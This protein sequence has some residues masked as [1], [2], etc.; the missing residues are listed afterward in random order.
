MVTVLQEDVLER[1]MSRLPTTD[2]RLI[3][4]LAAA[5]RRKLAASASRIEVYPGDELM[6]SGAEIDRLIFPENAPIMLS[7][8]TGGIA[9]D[10]GLI[11]HDGV[12]GWSRLLGDSPAPFSATVCV[13]SG[14]AITIP[15]AAMLDVA[16][17]DPAVIIAI[18]GFA[19]RFTM[20]IARTLGAALRDA[21]DRRIARLLL[22]IDDRTSGDTMAITHAAIARM[23][24]LRRA[25]VTDCLHVLEGERMLRCSRGRIAVRD[26]DALEECAGLA[27]VPADGLAALPVD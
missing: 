17:Q 2:N 19:Q 11:G 20:Q 13:Q 23:L 5:T 6:R 14:T 25:T 4:T 10:V 9:Q 7:V 22:M 8:S 18:L 12:I 26:R 24:N 27:Y 16:D 1:T 15:A 3:G 21:P